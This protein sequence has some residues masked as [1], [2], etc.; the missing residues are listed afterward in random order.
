MRL[1]IN[2]NDDVVEQLDVYA[3]SIGI[4]RSALCALFIGQGVMSYNK[5]LELI[6]AYAEKIKDLPVPKIDPSV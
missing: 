3:K 4:S 1:Q 5:S 2:I 6:G